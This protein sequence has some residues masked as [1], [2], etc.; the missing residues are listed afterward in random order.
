MKN[1]F[2]H[3]INYIAVLTAFVS[4]V[5]GTLCLLLFKSSSNS[6]FFAIGYFYTLCAALVNTFILL[7][8][9]INGIRKFK[10]YAEH[11]KTVFV[12]L[13]NIPIVGVYLEIL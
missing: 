3:S 6:G 11:L 4:F 7:L 10:D 1:R 13:L 8:V 12:V 5:L 9:L 2:K